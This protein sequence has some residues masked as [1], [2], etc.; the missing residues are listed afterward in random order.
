LAQLSVKYGL[1]ITMISKWKSDEVEGIMD[2]FNLPA[3][4]RKKVD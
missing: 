2:K 1:H 3:S 4:R